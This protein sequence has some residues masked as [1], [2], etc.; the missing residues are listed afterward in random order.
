MKLTSYGGAET[1]T[2]SKHLL[3]AGSLRILIDCGMFQGEKSGR[4]MNWEA[5]PFDPKSIDAVFLT[6]S[7]LDHS[8]YLPR[9]VRS[10]FRG[11]IYCTQP[12]REVTRIILLDSA[13]LQEEDAEQANRG[14]WSKHKPALPLYDTNDVEVTL[15]Q[16][17]S[18]EYG[19][20]FTVGNDQDKM[21][22]CYH[23]AGH[24]LGAAG[25]EITYDG[26]RVWFSG[27][28]GRLEDILMYPPRPPAAVD[29]L[30]MESTYG[31]RLHSKEDPS[32]RLAQVLRDIVDNKAVL[33]VPSFAVGRAQLLLIMLDRLMRADSSLEMPVYLSSPMATRVSALYEK[34]HGEHRIDEVEI[35]QVFKRVRMVEHFER[36]ARLNRRE[37]GPMVIVA[38]AGMLTGG[39]ILGHLLAHGNNPHNIVLLTGYQAPGTRGH[40]LASGERTLKMHGK[41]MTIQARV[42]MLDGLSAH[43]DQGEL[44]QWLA[45][46]PKP[47]RQIWLVHGEPQARETLAEKIR[48]TMGIPCDSLGIN[49]PVQLK[50]VS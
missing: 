40:T 42:E 23:Y 9:L 8:G 1:V 28:I 25:I 45:S 4:L 17:R 30:V 16:F 32:E 43:A 15:R 18:V 34:F 39:R 19:Q 37:G 48:Q 41:E 14:G 22:C 26:H 12:A 33:L 31:D 6:H 47:P 36:A 24:I 29:T 21:T 44:L 49:H 10:G 38:G 3:E 35:A 5:P 27:D 50:G 46:A 20:P 13:R 11:P 2:G 7:H